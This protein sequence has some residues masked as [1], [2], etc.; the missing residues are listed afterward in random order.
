MDGEDLDK[1]YARLAALGFASYPPE[2]YLIDEYAGKRAIPAP[3]AET[4]LSVRRRNC[5]EDPGTLPMH[6]V[7]R[8][9]CAQA[10]PTRRRMAMPIRT[11][12]GR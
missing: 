4:L 11:W 12:C 10:P 5:G 9:C 1:Y 7:P 8:A 2:Q 6:P 3:Q